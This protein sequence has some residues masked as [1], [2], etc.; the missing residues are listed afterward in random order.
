MRQRAVEHVYR[1]AVDLLSSDRLSESL[2]L[3]A[4]NHRW[5]GME[6]N[7]SK[8]AVPL[9]MKYQSMPTSRIKLA[10]LQDRWL[11][12][13]ILEFKLRAPL[14]LC[15]STTGDSIELNKY[16]RVK[17]TVFNTHRPKLCLTET[18]VKH[19]CDL[20]SSFCMLNDLLKDWNSG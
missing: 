8:W 13:D 20:L 9:W 18:K 7:S 1:K 4:E 2:L 6:A 17:I 15:C 10:R 5:K 12:I 16:T 3:T 14:Q 19:Q 11:I